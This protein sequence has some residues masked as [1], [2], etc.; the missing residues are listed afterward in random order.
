MAQQKQQG[1]KEFQTGKNEDELPDDD[2]DLDDDA[3]DDF[4]EDET[5][6]GSRRP[7]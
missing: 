4:D 1:P 2:L 7:N 6:K 3:D 5:D